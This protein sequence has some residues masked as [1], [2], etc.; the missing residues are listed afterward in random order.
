M[1]VYDVH[2]KGVNTMFITSTIFFFKESAEK[3]VEL[4]NSK[5]KKQGFEWECEELEGCLTLFGLI[6]R[7]IIRY[8]GGFPV[9]PWEKI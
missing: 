2:I 8:K 3:E 7:Y 5:Y 6:F 9:E 4:L 1:K